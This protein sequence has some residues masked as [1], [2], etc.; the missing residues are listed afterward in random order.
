MAEYPRE[1]RDR[2]RDFIER[3]EPR[4][5]RERRVSDIEDGLSVTDLQTEARQ[6]Y[7]ELELLDSF[8]LDVPAVRVEDMGLLPV[9]LWEAVPVPNYS[10]GLPRRWWRR[11]YP[12][13]VLRNLLYTGLQR[14]R[15]R[16]REDAILSRSE[17][18]T[19]FIDKASEFLAS[20][21]WGNR[22][23]SDRGLRD[24]ERR[25][26]RM[27]KF[28]GGPSTTV[29]GCVFN[30]HTRSRG[31]SAY[32][33]GAYYI[34]SN[35]HGAPTTPASGVLQAGTYIFGVDGGV[36]SNN[37]QWDTNKVCTLPGTPDVRL[38]F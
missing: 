5:G 36:Y 12:R 21:F 20:R 32:W 10:L 28:M 37:V 35:Y 9:A 11:I 25:E 4:E 31:L 38:Q 19:I 1:D 33:S 13:F 14:R 2:A 23:L 22:V 8:D 3:L 16:M 27:A 30:V 26:V 15:D 18:R 17:A 24:V 34:A 6:F 7:D 29:T